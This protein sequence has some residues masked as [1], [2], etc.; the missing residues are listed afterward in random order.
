MTLNAIMKGAA[1]TVAGITA[2]AL[3]IRFGG[4]LPVIKQVKEG[5]KGNVAGSI[6]G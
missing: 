6:F 2:V 4:N 5:L 1:G 3:A